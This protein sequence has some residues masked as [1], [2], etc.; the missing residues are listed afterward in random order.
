MRRVVCLDPG[1]GPGSVNGSPDGTYKE[2]EF[3]WDM[4]NRIRPLLTAAGVTVVGTRKTQN[5]YPSLTTRAAIG[6][7]AGA[8]LFVSIHTN[9]VPSTSPGSSARGFVA[10]TS[11][12]PLTA[13]RNKAACAIIDAM[14]R[15]GVVIFGTGMPYHAKFTVLTASASPAVLLEYGFHTHPHEVQLLKNSEYRDT[16]AKATC[17]GILDY[18]NLRNPDKPDPGDGDEKIRSKIKEHQTWLN[19]VHH[20]GL[21]VD[22]SFGPA[23]QKATIAAYQSVLNCGFNKNLVVD[24]SYGPATRAAAVPIQYGDNNTLVRI[25]QGLLYGHRFDP[26]G[27]DGSFGPGMLNTMKQFQYRSNITADGSCGPTTWNN[28]FSSKLG[29]FTY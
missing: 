25:A 6:N 4:Y 11:S 22:G 15:A 5:E 24:G 18:L 28:L 7:R 20:S 2:H 19:T 21:T 8:D 23:T 29:W 27:Y 14:R 12:P 9:A 17:E 26:N 1:H 3:A 16:L 10:Y 13:Q